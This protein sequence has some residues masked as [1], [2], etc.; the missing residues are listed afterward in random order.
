[1]TRL[2]VVIHTYNAHTPSHAPLTRHGRTPPLAPATPNFRPVLSRRRVSTAA[3]R[4]G[5]HTGPHLS[6]YLSIVEAF[7]FI[8]TG[9]FR[10][11]II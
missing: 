7:V 10:G 6:S 2:N 9:G 5:L 4:P 1:M 3:R 11:T 8:T